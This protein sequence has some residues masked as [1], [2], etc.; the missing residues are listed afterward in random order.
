MANLSENTICALS[1][2]Q[3][4]G[5]IAVIRVSGPN[6]FPIV[7]SI[8]SKSLSD[9]KSHTAHFG[10]IRSNDA[11]IDEV[12]VTVFKN[13]T[14]FTGEDS[15]EIACHGSV[16]IQQEIIQLLIEKGAQMA[17]PGEFSMRA[18]MNGKMDLSQTE[19]V[20]DLIAS[21]SKAQHQVAISQMRG[22]F[23][24]EIKDLRQQLLDFASLIELELDFSEEDVE[25]AD[26]SQLENLINTIQK[27]IKG[28]KQSFKLGN[29]IKNGVPVAIV[30]TPNSGKSTLL[31]S[32][33]NEDK[34]IVSSIAG[35]TRDFI[36]DEIMINDIS[37][38]FI[39][40]AGIRKTDDEIENMGIK[41]SFEQVKKAEIVLLIID[42]VENTER[43][44]LDEIN[45]FKGQN[46]QSFQT[47]IPVFNKIDQVDLKDFK[48]IEGKGVFIAAKHKTNQDHLMDALTA[49]VGALKVENQTIVTNIRHFEA[50]TNSLDAINKVAEG[51]EMQIPGDLLAMDIRQSLHHLGEITG[52]V[53]N[54]ELLGNIFANF[55]IGK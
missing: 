49:A 46:I 34:A 41:R 40:T 53:T 24:Q 22:G 44:I 4:M 20:A 38:R 18:F 27:E 11:V 28:L 12:L 33:L 10:E 16:Y 54:D 3:G 15:I 52:S 30:G 32:L 13:P 17:K 50:L 21:T 42:L 35:T 8:F 9:K 55:C 1:T 36:E 6:A 23:S 26:R 51:L 39:D 37:Y 7:E 47:F 2:A 14:S 29:V 43:A 31:N 45:L 19:A 25:F 48:N 5:A